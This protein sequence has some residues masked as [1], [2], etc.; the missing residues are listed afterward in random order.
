MHWQMAWASALRKYADMVLS[1]SKVSPFS[2][3]PAGISVSLLTAWHPVVC[4]YMNRAG[5]CLPPQSTLWLDQC[6]T[7]S[8]RPAQPIQCC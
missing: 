3:E 6:C 8:V 5:K 7:P 2:C 1:A 4:L